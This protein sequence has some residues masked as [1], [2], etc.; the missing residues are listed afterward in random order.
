M[1][2]IA[3]LYKKDSNPFYA[4]KKDKQGLYLN[5][6]NFMYRII[7]PNRFH[8]TCTVGNYELGCNSLYYEL[9]K[10][11]PGFNLYQSRHCAYITYR[12]KTC[13]F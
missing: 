7:T 11:A 4:F 9:S 3:K 1:H 5:I 13:F 6:I 2:I 12:V 10:K 8:C